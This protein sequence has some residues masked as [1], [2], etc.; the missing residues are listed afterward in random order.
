MK[1]ETVQ[2]CGARLGAEFANRWADH[3]IEFLEAEI[4]SLRQTVTN[5][6][7]AF[8]NNDPLS[9]DMARA[10]LDLMRAKANIV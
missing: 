2:E 8:L 10:A 1:H 6:S 4:R 7:T 9:H 3:R 5:V